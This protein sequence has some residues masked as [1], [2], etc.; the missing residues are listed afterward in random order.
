M[1]ESVCVFKSTKYIVQLFEGES[2]Q[3]EDY[4]CQQKF[5]IVDWSDIRTLALPV[6]LLIFL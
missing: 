5:E 6:V 1:K 4:K 2:L 3:I